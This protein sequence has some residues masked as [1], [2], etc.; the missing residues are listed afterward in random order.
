[1]NIIDCAE[2]QG[3]DSQSKSREKLW[4]SLRLGRGTTEDEEAQDAVIAAF[5]RLASNKYYMLRDLHLAGTETQVPLLLV[6]PVGIWVLNPSML[7]GVFRAR[8]DS[9][10]IIDDQKHTYKPADDNLL[11]ETESMTKAVVDFLSAYGERDLPVEP[12]LVFINPGIHIETLSPVVRI[13]LVDAL[14]RFISGIVQS[15][16]LYD[17]ERVQKI[18]ELFTAPADDSLEFGDGEQDG[19]SITSQARAQERIDSAAAQL[20]R[21]DTTFSNVERLP[22]SSRQWMILGGLILINVLVLA[23]FVIYL[24]FYS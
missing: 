20:E 22:F 4:S 6:G 1:M 16:I 5:Q 3:Q 10:E 18:V 7:R 12:V 11:T 21:I 13:V 14:D 8:G 15:R 23:A 24:V 2:E 9:W 19:F 17:S